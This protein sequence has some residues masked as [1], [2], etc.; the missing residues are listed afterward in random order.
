MGYVNFPP[1]VKD[2][3]DDLANRLRKL[4]T[5]QRFTVPV[6]TTDPTNRRNGDM[7]INST[8][9][10]LKAVDST[11]TIRIITWA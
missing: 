9:N 1:N 4:E 11:G 7:W 2:I 6:V 10:Q 8:T 3:I 5:G